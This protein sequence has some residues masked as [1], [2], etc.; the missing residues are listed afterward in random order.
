[1]SMRYRLGWLQGLRKLLREK[2][3]WLQ[4]PDAYRIHNYSPFRSKLI[5]L[6]HRFSAS[7]GVNPAPFARWSLKTVPNLYLIGINVSPKGNCFN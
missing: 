2:K 7:H 1:M 3:L 6:L 5:Q 4:K